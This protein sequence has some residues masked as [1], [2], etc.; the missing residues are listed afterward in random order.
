MSINDAL[1]EALNLLNQV[2]IK[3]ESNI[4]NMSRTFALLKA[5]IEFFENP[6]ED[7]LYE[8]DDK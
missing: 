6:K 1:Y 7:T 2:E 8:T 4:A 3:G 5:V